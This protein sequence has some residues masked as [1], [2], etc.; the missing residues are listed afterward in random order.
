MKSAYYGINE[1]AMLEKIREVKGIEV[2]R[3][4]DVYENLFAALMPLMGWDHYKTREIYMN[5]SDLNLVDYR[6]GKVVAR[7]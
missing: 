1:K 4:G 6:D 7:W 5:L 3:D 2:V